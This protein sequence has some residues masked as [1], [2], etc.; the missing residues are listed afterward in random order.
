MD[1]NGKLQ[2]YD[3]KDYTELVE[4]PVEIVGRDG[5]VRRYTFEDSIRLYQRRITF[6]PIRYRD[7][8][9]IRA[10]ANH[11]RSRID[12]LRRSYFH[13]F[14]WGTPEGQDSAEESFGDLA[15]E[16]AAFLCRVMGVEGRPEIRFDL[17][18]SSES[19]VSTWYV[20]PVGSP[21]GMLL[22]F[23]RFEGPA[24]DRMREQFFASL[25]GLERA[26]QT[27]GDAERL[28]AFHHTV[29][30][31]FVLT[32]RGGDHPTRASVS[33]EPRPVEV[34]TTPW[35]EVMEIV[36]KGDHDAALR[37]CRQ[38]VREQPWHRNAYVA[39]AMLAAFL[40]EHNVGEELALV[41]SRYFPDDG[42]L[43]YYLGLCRSRLG[44]RARAE[45]ALREALERTPGLVSA[46]TLLVIQLLQSRRHGEARELLRAGRVVEP[47]DKR[48]QSELLQLEQWIR[49]RRWMF[50]GGGASLLAGVVLMYTAVVSQSVALAAILVGAL[51][52]GLAWFAFRRQLDTIVVRQRFEEIST[53]LRRLHRQPKVPDPVVS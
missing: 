36:R 44:R 7:A 15:G 33:S 25:R 37:R 5:V 21:T 35:D 50:V 13:R 19:G 10:E 14:G 34:A 46:R 47:D 17:L 26:G 31:G 18:K 20:T 27:Q 49:W 39:G 9:L 51:L 42:T 38:L 45:Q 41:G 53:G 29:D 48:A 2:R 8:D 43:R 23:H 11:C 24:Q 4:F 1:K 30:C 3:R 40:G 32:G 6:A 12:Q 28:V 16:L 22:Y 52:V